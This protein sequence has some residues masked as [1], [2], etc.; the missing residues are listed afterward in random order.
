MRSYLRDIAL[1]TVPTADP[2]G[3]AVE[4]ALTYK[5]TVHNPGHAAPAQGPDLP[6]ITVD[7]ALMR[8]LARIVVNSPSLQEL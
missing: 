2:L 6:L 3:P 1:V 4:L 7:T 5:I 8:R